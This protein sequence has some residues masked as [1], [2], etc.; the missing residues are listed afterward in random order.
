MFG[1]PGE[2][3]A[4][5]NENFEMIRKLKGDAIIAMLGIRIYPGTE[6]EKIS[7]REG[8]ITARTDL[9]SPR[10]YISP[11]I[12]IDELTARVKEFTLA[13]SHCVVPGLGIRSSE[14][15]YSVLRKHYSEG[16]LWGYLS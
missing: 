15:M 5:L 3:R 8:L 14:A 10:F 11:E 16:P 13:N 4:S 1:A 6:L 2:N 7:I 9:L 12:P